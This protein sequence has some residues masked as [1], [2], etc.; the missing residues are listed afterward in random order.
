MNTRFATRS[1]RCILQ[2]PSCTLTLAAV[3]TTMLL[4]LLPTRSAATMSA[5]DF[6]L[7]GWW[8]DML[9]NERAG[10]FD[11]TLLCKGQFQ[12]IQDGP[13]LDGTGATCYMNPIAASFRSPTILWFHDGNGLDKQA[14]GF[15]MYAVAFKV[16][17]FT[18]YWP[19]D[20]NDNGVCS[21]CS[22][23][24][25]IRKGYGTANDETCDILESDKLCAHTSYYD[26]VWNVSDCALVAQVADDSGAMMA[27]WKQVGGF[28]ESKAAG[29]SKW[30]AWVLLVASLVATMGA[31]TAF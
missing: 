24:D 18:E 23:F 16:Q 2:P 31:V 17:N 9:V 1:F 28:D 20:C 19:T 11:P 25:P 7:T 21:D 5:N 14:P 10:L 13:L 3:F 4:C 29:G 30:N 12:P 26:G 8:S 6:Q 22:N 27:S 15:T